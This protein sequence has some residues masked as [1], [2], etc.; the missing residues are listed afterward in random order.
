MGIKQKAAK[1][2][3]RISRTYEYL[4]K[5]GHIQYPSQKYEILYVSLKVRLDRHVIFCVKYIIR[6]QQTPFLRTGSGLSGYVTAF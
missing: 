1:K 4:C 3:N 6:F 2:C 5:L